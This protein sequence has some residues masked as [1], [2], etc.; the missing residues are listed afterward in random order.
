MDESIRQEML[1]RTAYKSGFLKMVGVKLIDVGEGWT[2]GEME[3]NE[4]HLNPIGSTHGGVLFTIGDNMGG[5][6]IHTLTGTGCTTASASITYMNASYG[7]GK[8]IA[9]GKVL[10]RGKRMAMAETEITD[11]TGRLL[12]KFSGTYMILGKDGK[13]V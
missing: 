9:R 3:L 8:L 2:L 11:E 10:K 13:A 4:N 12:A 5:M 7:A 1:G 6:A